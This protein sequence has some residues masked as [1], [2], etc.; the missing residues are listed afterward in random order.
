M[1]RTQQ[2]NNNGYCQD[3]PLTWV[4]WDAVD[5]PLVEFTAA[6][7]ALRHK[8]PTFRRSRF[9]DGRPVLRGEGER[10]PD[11][12]WLDVDGS[13]MKPEDWDS[14]FGRSVGMFLNGDGIQGRDE[15]GRR[16]TDVNFV[17]YFNAHDDEVKFT[18]PSDEYAPAWDIIIDTAGHNADTEPVDAGGVLPVDAKSLVVLRAHSVPEVEPDHS[19]AA[20]LAALSQ[21]TT[22]ETAALTSPI[23]GT[24]AHQEGH[25][26]GQN[27]RMRT[28]ASTYRLQIRPGFT[29]QDAADTVE[30]LH[31]LGVDWVYL[32]PI[33]TAEKGSDHGYDVTDPSKVDPDRGGPEGLAALSRAARDAG[34]GVLVDIVPN[35]VGV[36]SP[37][38]N[39]WWWS[40]LKEGRQSPYAEAFDVDWD[41][42]GGRVRLPVLGNDDEL[43]KLE[44]RDG[45]LRYYDHRFPLA[46]GSYTAGDDPRDVHARQHY[47]LIGW[48]RADYDLNYRRFFAVNTLAGIKVEVPRVFDE[49]HAEVLRWFREGLADGLRIDHPDGLADPEGYLRRLREATGGAYLLIEK[50]LEPGEELPASFECEGTTGYD[51]LA[52]VD[53]LFVD[54]EAQKA[55]DQLDGRL[56]GGEPADYEDMI[57]GTK[58]RITD[59]IL[60]SEILR[61]GRLLSAR[62]RRNEVA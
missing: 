9:F 49:A 15:R 11:I 55:L 7:N 45:E 21:T 3:S 61:L 58:R 41:F 17:L 56:R 18:L 1:G 22:S 60:H 4:N 29:L 46:E 8:H 23:I 6:V 31:N 14:G 44:V 20:S 2:G 59:G 33:L 5:Q 47:E 35:H 28:P 37:H 38:Q 40:L 39:P 32:S 25:V 16:I 54:A 53:R 34:M 62:S 26:E 10:L 30:Y 13:T 48:R 36:A 42:A 12:E 24:G 57:R 19:V 51:A 52:D 50:I 27:S 43:D